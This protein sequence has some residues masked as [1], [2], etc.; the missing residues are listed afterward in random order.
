[1]KRPLAILLTLLL[2]AACLPL[3]VFAAPAEVEEPAV[4]AEAEA[5]DAYYILDEEA[6]TAFRIDTDG[7]LWLSD[8]NQQTFCLAADMDGNLWLHNLEDNGQIESSP[9]TTSSCNHIYAPYQHYKTL[10][11]QKDATSHYVYK[12]YNGKCIYCGTITTG[13]SYDISESTAPHTFGSEKL[14]R[15][16]HSSSDP[17]KHFAIYSKTC[18]ASGC[19]YTS[20]RKVSTG[21][22]EHS[23]GNITQ[24]LPPEEF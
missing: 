14:I 4:P 15:S 13:S 20:T 11:D 23:C 16:D 2:A 8:L 5:P 21:C 7:H 1:M 19:G 3:V 22:T 10:Y 9:Q 24:T 18:T 17:Y 6:P 12:L